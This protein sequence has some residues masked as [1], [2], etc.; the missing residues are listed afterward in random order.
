[1]KVKKNKKILKQNKSPV[2]NIVNASSW[3]F[4]KDH[5]ETW[6]WAKG[7]FSPEECQKIIEI[8]NK[9]NP[10]LGKFFGKDGKE[11]I[12]PIVRKSLVSWIAPNNDTEWIY[13]KLQQ[14]VQDINDKFF[15]FH[16]T[17]INECLQFTKYQ[18]PDGHYH[19]HIDKNYNGP[20]RKLSLT[21]QLT[22]PSKYKGGELEIYQQEKPLVVGKEQGMA[23]LFPSYV[24][25][26]VTPVIKG[27]RCSL[28]GWFTGDP[29]K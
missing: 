3:C 11:I 28:V 1:M 18:A 25:H 8:G 10:D 24:L 9:L 27:E 29:F 20:I 16:L 15:K 7:V 22:D 6:A 5:A 12:N 26:K 13:I 19:T 4:Q 2:I 21:V 14:V 17:G 23:V